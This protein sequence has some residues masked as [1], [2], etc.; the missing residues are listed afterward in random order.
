VSFLAYGLPN[1]NCSNDNQ[2]NAQLK[3]PCEDKLLARF[4]VLNAEQLKLL[5]QHRKADRNLS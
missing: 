3:K 2:T 1:T 4:F 5:Q